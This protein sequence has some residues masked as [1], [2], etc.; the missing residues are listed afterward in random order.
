MKK[1][2]SLELKVIKIALP[3]L[4][5][6]GVQLVIQVIFGIY[7][8]WY[9]FRTIENSDSDHALLAYRFLEY[10]E[11]YMHNHGLIALFFAGI[12]TLLILF[13]IR[14]HGYITGNWQWELPSAKVAGLVC[15]LGIFAA[16]GLGRLVTAVTAAVSSYGEV[17]DSFIKNPLLFQILTLCIVSPLVEEVIFRDM[18]YGQLKETMNVVAASVVSAL[19][20]GIYHGNLSQGIYGFLLGLLFCFVREYAGTMIAPVLFHMSCNTTAL[21]MMYLPFS[22]KVDNRPVAYWIVL[23]FEL[24]GMAM[25]LWVMNRMR[26]KRKRKEEEK[27]V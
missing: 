20:F 6:V 4:V 11:E 17:Q 16:G 10:T 26:K 9:K 3:L 5:Y 24:A 23:G 15:G 7:S 18:M 2:D 27:N 8:V 14:K 1:E 21:V 19:L 13:F 22:Q 12:I 25:I